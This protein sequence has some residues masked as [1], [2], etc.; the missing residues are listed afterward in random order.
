MVHYTKVINGISQYIE[1]DMLEKINGSWKAWGIGTAVALIVRKA[2]SVFEQ[3]K[4]NSVIQTLGLIDGEMVDAET[5][6]AELLKQ[7]QKRPTATIDI[8]LI[9]TVTYSVQDV[10]ALRRCILGG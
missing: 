9:G 1:Q 2:P 5:I 7:A 8:P 4:Q 6:F 10:E 3:L